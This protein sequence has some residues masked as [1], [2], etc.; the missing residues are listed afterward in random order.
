MTI[1]T[2]PSAIA[3][4]TT[5]VA[6]IILT[7]NNNNKKQKINSSNTYISLNDTDFSDNFNV[8]FFFFFNV[9]YCKPKAKLLATVTSR[10]FTYTADIERTATS[11]WTN[12]LLLV[13]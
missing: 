3:M 7:N 2:I 11:S 10:S 4:I 6:T 13:I 5:I 1:V 12:V 8:R 9:S